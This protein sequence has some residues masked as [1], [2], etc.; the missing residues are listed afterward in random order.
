I[1]PD[2]M[3]TIRDL[4]SEGRTMRYRLVLFVTLVFCGVWI[5]SG[6]ILPAN[7]QPNGNGAPGAGANNQAPVLSAI[8][9]HFYTIMFGDSKDVLD[10]KG[11]VAVGG[12]S[13]HPV[14]LR[15]GVNYK[16]V[17]KTLTSGYDNYM[18]L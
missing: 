1:L 5:S 2:I 12:E 7:A 13:F 10:V 15:A 4:P 14:Y 8:A 9:N 16:I 3:E 18:W 6:H 17:L 11:E